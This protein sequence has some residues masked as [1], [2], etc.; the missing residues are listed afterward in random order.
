YALLQIL[1]NTN[2]KEAAQVLVS[3]IPDPKVFFF[4]EDFNSLH[5][6]VDKELIPSLNEIIKNSRNLEKINFCYDA[7][8][9]MHQKLKP[10]GCNPEIKN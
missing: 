10:Q 3:L 8:Q 6:V 2:T 7:I 4:K 1:N 9:K 5:K